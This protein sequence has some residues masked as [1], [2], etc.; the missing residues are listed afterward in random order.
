LVKRSDDT[1]AAV[2]NRLKWFKTDVQPIINY[3]R[4]T[5]RLIKINGEQPIEG[6][7]KDV[8]KSLK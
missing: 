7:F 8:L 2:K 3:Y 4:R 1:L 6:V 5:G